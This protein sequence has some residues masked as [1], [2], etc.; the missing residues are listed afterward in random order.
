MDIE[1]LLQFL[2]SKIE[3]TRGEADKFQAVRDAVSGTVEAEV[4]SLSSLQLRAETAENL[5]GEKDVEIQSLKAEIEA[6]KKV[7]PA[8]E[9]PV[10]P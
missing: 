6:L 2:D 4:A 3:A 1:T 8:P 5:N 10:T 7:E 9:E